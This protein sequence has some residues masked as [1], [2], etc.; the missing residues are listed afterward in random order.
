MRRFQPARSD[1]EGFGMFVS[2]RGL[3]FQKRLVAAIVCVAA[4]CLTVQAGIVTDSYDDWSK[5]GTQGEKGWW[6][7]YYDQTADATSGYDPAEDFTMFPPDTWRGSGYDL[8][9]GTSPWTELGRESLHPA[10]PTP[11]HWPIR[12]WVSD[13][14]L[15]NAVL[16]W[17][18]RKTNTGGGNGVTGLLLVN[19][20]AVDMAQISG[21][22]GGGILRHASQALAAGDI[23]ELALGSLGEDGDYNDGADGSAN[24][25]TIHDA[26]PPNL[27]IAHSIYDYPFKDLQGVAGW[28]YGYY[29]LTADGD[30]V[31]QTDD[32]IPFASDAWT[33]QGWNLPGDPPW[34]QLMQ[35][36]AHPN[37]ESN[38]GEHWVI[39]RWVSSVEGRVAIWWSL[40]KA[41]LAGNGTSCV[42][43][44]NGVRK[45]Y[46]AVAGSDG[47][48]IKRAIVANL[49]LGDIVDLALTPV[50]PTGARD[51]GADGSRTRMWVVSDLSDIPD[52]DGDGL[53]DY[54]DNC[55]FVPNPDQADS[56]GD[57]VGDAC[58]N[59]P[60]IPNPDQADRD[61]DGKGDA[62]EPVWIAHSFDDW[63]PAAQG[64][65]N[66]YYGYYNRADDIG[67]G[68]G[69]YQPDDFKEFAPAMWIGEVWRIE[70]D[71][72]RSPW[73]FV[74]R[75]EAHPNGGN[76][77]GEH[78]AIR[79]WVSTYAGEVALVWHLRK[80]NPNQAGV[81]GILYQNGR[82]LDRAMVSGLDTTGVSRSVYTML[83][84]GDTV[85][86]ALTPEGWCNDQYDYSDGSFNILAVTEDAN[87]LAGLKSNRAIVADSSK[88]FGG[89][90]GAHNW[91]YGYYDVRA[92]VTTG[93]GIYGPDDFIEFAPELWNGSKW[94]LFDN[95]ATGNGPWTEITCNGGHP[96]GNGQNDDSVH[97]AVRRWVSPVAGTVRIDCH[98]HQT[99]AYGDGVYGRVF[100][101]ENPIGARFSHAAG[102]SFTL[103][104]DVALGDTLDFA[105]DPDGAGN[106]EAAGI[107]AVNDSSDGTLFLI[108]VTKIE[109]SLACPAD[110][111]A[112]ACGGAAACASCPEGSAANDIKFTWTNAAAYEYLAIYE[113]D[114]TVDPPART[115]IGEPAKDATEF[116]LAAAAPGAHTYA[117]KAIS[118]WFA[119]ETAAVTVVVPEPG[120]PV[121]T[122]DANS[123][124]KI[125]IAD[126]VCILGYL[127]GSPSDPCKSPKCMANMDVNNDAKV[128][129]ADA[130]SVLG[131]LFTGAT[132]KAPDGTEI[133]AGDEGCRLYPTEKVALP[134]EYP[135]VP[136]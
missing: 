25:L 118:G 81:T 38:G 7:G 26:M 59:C 126:A 51:D 128:D 42:L 57:G 93:D 120:T 131:Y 1:K 105:I 55:P 103:E 43:F 136:K 53:F 112:C 14:D 73:T 121:F 31:Y 106:L 129:I 100:R 60:D 133:R 24:R 49:A 98:L 56:D 71:W 101:N 65:N 97:W 91:Y 18:M 62:C 122:G 15:P 34:T 67:L 114:L 2:W 115:L 66:W 35:E 58:D 99:S 11:T 5:S 89:V 83:H 69:V 68:D 50:G 19:G 6:Y 132:L 108:T 123:D 63:T 10:G 12:R 135:C 32:F 113:L 74:G 30:G 33:G 94:D 125:D 107:D 22:N 37:S 64:A 27:P 39:R 88:E 61:R 102:V 46:G 17:Q 40:R 9:I 47:V 134:C 104:T 82:E 23:V 119:C 96:A 52:S 54:E 16:V 41:N 127:F 77:G 4:A 80:M 70:P 76:S 20:V 130:V 78:W 85:D 72:G 116:L 92:D 29:N 87:V 110:F 75:G 13:R 36:D 117:L 28:Y 44:V 84:V 21:R 124:T 111:A 3:G 79:R 8:A 95:S 90:Q 86:L 45:D 109:R 48:G